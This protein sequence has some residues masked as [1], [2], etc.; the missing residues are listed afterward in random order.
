M[1]HGLQKLIVLFL[2]TACIFFLCGAAPFTQPA[3][4]KDPNV[5]LIDLGEM[6]RDSAPGHG[7][8]R[9]ASMDGAS[10]NKDGTKEGDGAG[11]MQKEAEKELTVTVEDDRIYVNGE[12]MKDLNALKVRLALDYRNN[13][14]ARLVDDY[15]AYRTYMEVYGALKDAG[16][17]PEEERS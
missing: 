16:I 5:R 11:T 6:V 15:A 9:E 8:N 3:K 7:G 12:Q 10:E 17:I 4:F 14:N 1:K 13:R 2:C